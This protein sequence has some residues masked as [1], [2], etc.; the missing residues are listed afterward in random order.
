MRINQVRVGTFL[1][2]I[3]ISLTG[4]VNCL[5]YIVAMHGSLEILIPNVNCM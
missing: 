4:Q 2:A 5:W 3:I 1:L